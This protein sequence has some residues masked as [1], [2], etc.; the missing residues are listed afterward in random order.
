ML[1]LKSTQSTLLDLDWFYNILDL[2]LKNSWTNLLDSGWFYY[3]QT[4]MQLE[5]S[6]NLLELSVKQL[7]LQSSLA[8]SISLS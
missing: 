2:Y 1:D 3:N 8:S 6:E 5:K 4:G 7:V